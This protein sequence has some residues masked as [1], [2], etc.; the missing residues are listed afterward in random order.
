MHCQWTSSGHSRHC[1]GTVHSP[2]SH[3]P[4]T[5]L[6][7]TNECRSLRTQGTAGVVP[8]DSHQPC[9]ALR[10]PLPGYS[11]HLLVLAG[12]GEGGA[13]TWDADALQQAAGKVVWPL[14]VTWFKGAEAGTLG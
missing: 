9:S 13:P 4:S 14:R 12:G 6:N 5:L 10:A 2:D 1:A 8:L 7:I 11:H 3:D